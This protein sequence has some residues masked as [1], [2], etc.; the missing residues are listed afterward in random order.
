MKVFIIRLNKTNH[1]LS[2]DSENVGDDSFEQYTA[3]K[4]FPVRQSSSRPHEK[5]LRYVNV[6][7][8]FIVC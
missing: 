6:A 4:V 3:V 7:R 1:R 8:H 5:Y 2:S